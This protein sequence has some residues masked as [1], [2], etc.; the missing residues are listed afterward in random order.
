MLELVRLKASKSIPRFLKLKL[1]LFLIYCMMFCSKLKKRSEFQTLNEL[2]FKT[3]TDK[4]EFARKK[5]KI[6]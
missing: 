4:F 1:D 3:D 6:I 5:T 2:L